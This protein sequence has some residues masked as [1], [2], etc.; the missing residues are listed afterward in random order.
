ML[1][2]GSNQALDP[3]QSEVAKRALKAF[4]MAFNRSQHKDSLQAGHSMAHY[5]QVAWQ[6]VIQ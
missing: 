2:Q 6:E 4:T 5:L 1:L 3:Q